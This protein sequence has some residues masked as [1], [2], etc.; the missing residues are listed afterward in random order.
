MI[1]TSPRSDRDPTP[2]ESEPKAPEAIEASGAAEVI[3]DAV[4]VAVAVVAKVHSENTYSEA[5]ESASASGGSDD[6]RR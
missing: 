1:L 3:E 6:T 5:S 2:L 4:A